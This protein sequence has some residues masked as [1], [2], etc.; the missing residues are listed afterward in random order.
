MLQGLQESLIS[1]PRVA[2]M[3]DK[4]RGACICSEAAL[5]NCIGLI[6]LLML[7]TELQANKGNLQIHGWGPGAPSVLKAL[8]KRSANSTPNSR[9]LE[10]EQVESPPLPPG[11]AFIL[12][13]VNLRLKCVPL[14]MQPLPSP[15][16][17]LLCFHLNAQMLAVSM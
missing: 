10:V 9:E 7:C 13:P 14:L 1:E 8:A 3:S 5:S 11:M 6:L 12:Q 16:L 15:C 2:I 4:E 17:C